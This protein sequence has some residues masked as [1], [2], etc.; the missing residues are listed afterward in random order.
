MDSAA[1]RQKKS[2]YGGYDW[3]LTPIPKVDNGNKGK[4]GKGAGKGPNNAA[5]ESQPAAVKSSVSNLKSSVSN[6]TPLGQKGVSKGAP[7]AKSSLADKGLGKGEKG[8][9]EKVNGVEGVSPALTAS[10]KFAPASKAGA[11]VGKSFSQ[12]VPKSAATFSAPKSAPAPA[13]KG[14]VESKGLGKGHASVPAIRKAAGIVPTIAKAK[15]KAPET[16]GKGAQPSMFPTQAKGM[17]KGGKMGG[18]SGAIPNRACRCGNNVSEEYWQAL[19]SKETYC[20]NCWEKIQARS[21]TN[22]TFGMLLGLEAMRDLG[23]QLPIAV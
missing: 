2:A 22:P 1:K 7:Q 19:E 21:P 5:S 20:S 4:A 15:A 17:G 12:A 10:A 23:V 3:K 11:P 13:T 18:K 14:A 6:L 9:G 16:T 8:K